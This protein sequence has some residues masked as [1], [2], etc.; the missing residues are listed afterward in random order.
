MSG[1]GSA[2]KQPKSC[3]QFAQH[4]PGKAR[5]SLPDKIC[6][7][8]AKVIFCFDGEAIAW[9]LRTVLIQFVQLGFQAIEHSLAVDQ[10]A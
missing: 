3:S 8:L 7:N 1:L 10:S 4:V 9:H 5:A 2:P 6:L